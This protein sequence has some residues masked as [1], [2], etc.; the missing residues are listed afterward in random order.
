MSVK[1][2]RENET[3]ERTEA[4]IVEA[5]RNRIK[6]ASHYINVNTI[7]FLD[8]GHKVRSGKV[9]Q[10]TNRGV[11]IEFRG[12]YKENFFFEELLQLE[13]DREILVVD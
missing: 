7:T 6:L 11:M 13:L 9:V 12:G 3:I 1:H 10:R 8:R 5:R 2:M 4:R